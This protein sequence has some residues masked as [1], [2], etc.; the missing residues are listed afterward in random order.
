MTH[1]NWIS[2]VLAVSV[3]FGGGLA[4]AAALWWDDL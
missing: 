4:I 1:D 3:F 2:L